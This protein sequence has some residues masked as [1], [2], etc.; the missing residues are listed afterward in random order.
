MTD[1]GLHNSCERWQTPPEIFDP[2]MAEFSFDLDA[3]ADPE[4]KRLPVYL[5][6]ALSPES[7]QQRRPCM[8]CVIVN[9]EGE[10]YAGF[11]DG[12]PLW[13]RTKRPESVLEEP[14]ADTVVR[15]LKGLGF[16]KVIKRSANGVARKWVPA[17]LDASAVQSEADRRF[18]QPH[19]GHDAE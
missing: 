14:I 16:E 9:E 19:Y 11:Q 1:A 13:Y 3:A 6:N 15:Q 8:Q 7:H 17:D 10:L 18:G 4:T 2:P 12:K 5:I